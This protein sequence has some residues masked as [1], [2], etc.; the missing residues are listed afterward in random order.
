MAMIGQSLLNMFVLWISFSV[1]LGIALWRIRKPGI[2]YSIIKD[3][4]FLT[5]AVFILWSVIS[6]LFWTQA[7]INS[8]LILFYFLAG[9]LSY[10]IGYTNDLAKSQTTQKLLLALGLGLV[11]LTYYQ[12]FS[13]GM[14]RPIG[15][16]LNWN[17]HA[18]F[19][20]MILLPWVLRYTL[21][22]QTNTL[23]LLLLCI[24][25]LLFSFALGLTQSR[26]ALL[27]IIVAT[28]CIAVFSWR[29]R[30]SVSYKNYLFLF[31]AI[32]LGYLYSGLF[33]NETIFQR[34]A[35]ITETQTY[36]AT[37]SGRHL[38]WDSAWQ[39]YLDNPLTGWGLDAYSLL[40]AQYK[41]PLT[42]EIGHY[43]HN[44]YL[45]LL[46]ELGPIGLLTF[47]IFIFFILRKFYQ[48]LQK[49]HATL[50]AEKTDAVIL[51]ATCLGMLTHTF[52]TFHLYHESMLVLFAYYL[53]CA[54]KNA[55]TAQ[56]VWVKNYAIQITRGQIWQY[57]V[58]G[59]LMFLFAIAYGTA[60]YYIV[61]AE[62]APSLPEKI[63]LYE[64]ASLLITALDKD[65]AI[66]AHYLTQQLRKEK[67]LEQRTKIAN[68]ALIAVNVAI[69]K[70]PLFKW[71]YI[72]KA[73]IL[74]AIQ[75]DYTDVGEQYFKTLTI[76]PY[77]IDYRYEYAKLLAQ[78]GQHKQALDILWAGWGLLYTLPYQK[79]IAYLYFQLQMI[80]QYGNTKQIAT[81][82][83]QIEKLK[84][85]KK[86]HAKGQYVFEK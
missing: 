67:S 79:G 80:Y 50:S 44:D 41:D 49:D 10:F 11:F 63:R 36:T 45:Q 64:K 56:G 2:Y 77:L 39:M 22:F 81:I 37:S 30:I 42:N 58:F 18:G 83:R 40:F 4:A 72:N 59:L 24:I 60:S 73:S 57:R 28:S 48:L 66:N 13:L 82:Q 14:T 25:S 35:S 32:I 78:N 17:T 85:L 43:A 51:L 71:N 8:F 65:E 26:G 62:K 23:Q 3:K 7:G 12:F 33:V 16:L 29:Q 46:L 68:K 86:Y 21:T 70:L 54:S 34:I 27:I 55:H 76:D 75:S 19:L 38:L 31:G 9:L 53:G 69:E 47:L 15:L 5:Y 6:C 20:A 84:Q 52:F 74:Q 1:L 61:L